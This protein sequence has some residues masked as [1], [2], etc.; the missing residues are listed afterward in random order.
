MNLLVDEN[1]QGLT[2]DFLRS[3]GHD[4]RSVKDLGLT[5]LADP[6][7]FE[8]ARKTKR[9]LLTYNVDFADIRQ[10]FGKHHS[11]IIRLRI[12]NQRLV[13]MHP[14]LQRALGR[15]AD[16]DLSNSLVTISDKRIRMRKTFSE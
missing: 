12:S 11:G 5:S 2:V 4:V 7:I 9:V 8:H 16:L 15:I 13:Y 6:V 14:V 1:V 3:L 10:L